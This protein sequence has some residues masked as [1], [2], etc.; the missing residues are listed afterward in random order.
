MVVVVQSLSCVWR[1]A[2][3]WTVAHQA[4]L[5][6]TIFRNLHR[7]ISIELVMVSSHLILYLPFSLL[8][9]VFPSIRVFSNESVLRIR[10]PKYWSF[11][12]SISP[13]NEYSGLISF[14]M[15][16][17]DLLAVQ[18]TLKSLLQHH[19]LEA[20]ILQHS[21]FFI[22]PEKMIIPKD[23]CTPMFTAALSAIARTWKKPR[24]CQMNG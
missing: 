19:S 24:C 3:P 16:C 21:V 7:L 2:T 9:S 10:W 5:F 20:S 17:F 22:Y 1:F 23:T 8:P 14:R 6:F 11:S 4:S 18:G 13:C 15:D 12:F